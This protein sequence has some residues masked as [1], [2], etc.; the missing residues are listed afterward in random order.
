MPAFDNTLTTW[1]H[2]VMTGKCSVLTSVK[3]LMLS[4]HYLKIRQEH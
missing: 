4:R 3:R 2:D 1:Q